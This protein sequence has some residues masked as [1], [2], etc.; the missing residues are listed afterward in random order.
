VGTGQGASDILGA[1]LLLP[2]SRAVDGRAADATSTAA[3]GLGSN[4]GEPGAKPR[5]GTGGGALPNRMQM[6]G[7]QV[8][9]CVMECR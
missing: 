2:S 1:S 8:S 5:A 7:M 6:S 9:V 4:H 3:C